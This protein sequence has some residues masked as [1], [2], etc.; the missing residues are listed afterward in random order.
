M[1]RQH[2]PIKCKNG[3]SM[4]V[5]ASRTHYCTPRIDGARLYTHV[6]VGFPS[7][8]VEALMPFAENSSDPTGTVYGWVPVTILAQ[9]IKEAGGITSSTSLPPMGTLATNIT[10]AE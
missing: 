4:S 7:E 10:I 2:P 8:R 1:V 3:L 5:Q 9:V 6:E